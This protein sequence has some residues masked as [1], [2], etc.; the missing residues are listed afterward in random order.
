MR[1][2][3]AP[4]TI[5]SPLTETELPNKSASCPSEELSFAVWVPVAQPP[6]GLTKTYAEPC[7]TFGPTWS[8]YAPTATVSPA[9]DTALPKESPSTPS[10]ALSFAVSV[11]FTHGP[12]GL[13]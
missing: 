4:T 7:A 3:D 9:I 5:V 12:V 2:L 11:A 8:K 1:S 13:T 10:D 6:P